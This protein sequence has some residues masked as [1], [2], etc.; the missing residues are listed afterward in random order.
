MAGDRSRILSISLTGFLAHLQNRT[1]SDSDQWLTPARV[2]DFPPRMLAHLR[3]PHFDFRS[4]LVSYC[5]LWGTAWPAR[6]ACV[7]ESRESAF[8]PLQ[9]R[10]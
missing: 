5:Y 9:N 3:Q 4:V 1:R 2:L 7:T 8:E 10:T 6:R